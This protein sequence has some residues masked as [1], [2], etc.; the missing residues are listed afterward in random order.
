MQLIEDI[1]NHNRNF[2]GGCI[3]FIGLNGNTNHAILIRSVLSYK[4]ELHYQAGA[5]I[6]ES[7]NPESELQEVNNK[8]AAVRKAIQYA[9]NI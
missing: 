2:Y 4:N 5:G 3:G 8:L 9:Q 6:V 1:E 7:S